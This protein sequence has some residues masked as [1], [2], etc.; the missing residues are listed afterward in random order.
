MPSALEKEVGGHSVER[1]AVVICGCSRPTHDAPMP[2]RAHA[3][4]SVG[5][6]TTHSGGQLVRSALLQMS[7]AR[8]RA[9]APAMVIRAGRKAR[10]MVV[11]AREGHDLHERARSSRRRTC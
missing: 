11:Y 10:G 3:P 4:A 8:R 7:M 2:P 5:G 1:A 9:C 6:G